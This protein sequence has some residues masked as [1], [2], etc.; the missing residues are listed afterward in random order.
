[1]QVALYD[2]HDGYYGAGRAAVGRGGDFFTNVSVG[3]VFGRILA[4][5][6]L[7]MWTSLDRPD[8][9]TLVEQGANDGQL[10]RDILE[11]LEGTPLEGVR[12]LIIE[13]SEILKKAQTARLSGSQ[14]NWVPSPAE[15]PAFCGVHFSNELFD[16]LPFDLLQAHDG[17]W[18][19][20]LVHSDRHPTL[21]FNPAAVGLE[22][23][24]LPVRP[25]GFLT[26]RR[27]GQREIL[28]TLAERLENG[29]VLTIDYGMTRDEL[30]A[31]HRSAG[32]LA[33][34]SHHRRDASPLECPG[35]K[36]ITAHVDFTA[37]V[38]DACACGFVPLGY[39]DQHH[40]LVGAA[41]QLLQSLDGHPPTPTSLK[42]MR[43][44]R[45]LLHPES[46]GTQFHALLLAKT[47]NPPAT[48]S[49]FQHARSLH[50]PFGDILDGRSP[51]QN[52]AT[53]CGP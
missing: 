48:L 2:P 22:G 47:S 51:L 25:D 3:P 42:T 26:E 40:F 39:T 27:I 52:Q 31:P 36:D 29:F 8:G 53:Y 19:Q 23:T 30:L 32:T 41:T 10:A 17:G 1:M 6:F 18:R 11:A 44:L 7:E 28:A 14:V 34:Y 16:A 45:L 21:F 9:F 35:E 46:M 37:L 50:E 49:G 12:F 24:G 43:A 5:Q 13:P 20:M 4:G 33:C 38:Q 15:L